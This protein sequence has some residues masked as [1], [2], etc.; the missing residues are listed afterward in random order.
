MGASPRLKEYLRFGA[1]GVLNTATDF[2]VLNCLLTG[3]ATLGDTHNVVYMV[4]KTLSFLVAV[5]QSYFL[6]K[7]WVF[8]AGG[9]GKN[10]EETARF[11]TVSL[12]GLAIN[13]AASS[14]VFAALAAATV[15]DT[16]IRANIGA[17]TGTLAVLA[18]NYVGY[19]FFVFKTP[20]KTP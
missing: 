7:Y 12:A 20:T 3:F 6:N 13:I 19:K 5:V 17:I 11:F 16:R 1:T 15:T 2:V 4:A 18:W 14:L 10:M 9:H 8:R